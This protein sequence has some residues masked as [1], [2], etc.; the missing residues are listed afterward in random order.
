MEL[1]IDQ[2]R[3]EILDSFREPG[4]S[5]LLAPPGTGKSTRVPRFLAEG[6]RK[7]IC[8]EPRRI[9]A[10]S[11]AQR[12]AS[13]TGGT[14][15][16]LVGYRVRFDKK[17]SRETRIEFVS[18]GVFLRQILSE[19]SSL[20]QYHA[21]L[22]DEFHERQ[23]ETD[24][25]FGYLLAQRNH[26]PHLR[27][28]ILSATLDPEP[29]RKLWPDSRTVEV[30]SPLHDVEIRHTSRPT[31]FDA[32]TA[33]DRAVQ[34]VLGLAQ[35]GSSPDYLVFLP[36]YREIRQA[37][38]NLREHPQMKGWDILALSGEQSPEEQDRAI[39][40][41]G[42]PRVVIATNLAES[43]LTV[44]GIRA[45]VDSGL[46]RRMDYDP[47][48]GINALRTVRVSLFSARQRSGRAGRIDPGICVRL[49]SERE[50]RSLSL[51]DLPECQ[52]LDLSD[53]LLQNLAGK[54]I[55]PEDFPW[56]D[57]PPPENLEQGWTLLRQLGAVTER[58]LTQHGST[59]GQLPLHP[60]LA[61]LIIEGTK[62][63]VGPAAARLAALIE[64]E[65]L[66]IPDTPAESRY[67]ERRDQADFEADLRLLDAIEHGQSPS[68][69]EGAR[70]GAAR[71]V[72]QQ[73]KRLSRGLP[74]G[75]ADSVEEMI[76]LRQCC[77]AGF[78]DRVARRLDRG[79]TTYLCRDGSTARL[80]RRTRVT[81]DEWI[82]AL[83][84]KEML[85]QGTRTAILCSPTNLEP[86]WIQESLGD[87]LSRNTGVF[88]DPTGRLL[89]QEILQLDAIELERNT[90]GD[91]NDSDRASYFAEEAIN[92]NI[93]LRKWT[94]A[95]D[96]WIQRMDCLRLHFPE[97]EIPEFDEEAKRTVLEMIAHETQT[98]KEFRN[99]EILPT[100]REWLSPEHRAMMNQILPEHYPIPERRKPLNIDYGTPESPRI[101]LRIQEAMALKKHPHIANNRCRLTVEL[102]AP[103]QR[104]V[105]VTQDLEAFWSTSYPQIR[106]DL[107]G[108]YPK[109]HW[110]ES[111]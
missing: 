82:L 72:L 106:K 84:K 96:R 41:S 67:A 10:R 101:S 21:I 62:R 48:R 27:I 26:H 38:R 13:E 108:R 14:P 19:P 88:E 69:G 18:R 39:R 56:I 47:S 86:S 107:R 32:R 2:H 34:A 35:S 52:R 8:I 103:N 61:A 71:Q 54:Q 111:V 78:P 59:L 16:G 75:S 23:L 7:V 45:V 55:A 50:E 60:R 6:D 91:A 29:I 28:G 89:R 93:P 44:E 105:Q 9:A 58:T 17:I 31:Q 102:L 70:L 57:P 64:E 66:I 81:G 46:A 25:I 87:S 49:W 5:I 65:R 80:D 42:R 98:A 22:L 94:P 12:V 33:T 53:W 99:A 15:G 110:P 63:G 4:L 24:W 92:G 97:F 83:D 30:E 1:P 74:P 37:V 76:R 3:E 11:L 104:P 36:G 51:Q 20:D 40:S 77:L 100:L 68:P 43:S 109:H 79:T 95:V 90:L 85:V 73:A